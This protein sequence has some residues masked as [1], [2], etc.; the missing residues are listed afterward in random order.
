MPT[1]PSLE[2]GTFQ[3]QWQWDLNGK[4]IT[5]PLGI[6]SIG[7][8]VSEDNTVFPTP[9]L[10]SDR[11]VIYHK[12]SKFC[13]KNSVNPES[14]VIAVFRLVHSMHSSHRIKYFLIEN[15]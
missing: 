12:N 9:R 6:V 10:P 2:K 5:L 13:N 14:L 1:I 7:L 3:A 11:L 15:S 8:S 4:K